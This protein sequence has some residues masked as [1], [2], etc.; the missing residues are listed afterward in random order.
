MVA[1][2]ILSLSNH[3]WVSIDE[4]RRKKTKKESGVK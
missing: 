3:D 4:R 1:L 2:E